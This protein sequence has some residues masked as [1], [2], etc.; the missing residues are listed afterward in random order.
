[1]MEYKVEMMQRRAWQ[2]AKAP[3]GAT[4]NKAVNSMAEADAILRT[5]RESWDK[6]ELSRYNIYKPTKYR[7]VSRM[8][9]E[10]EAGFE[11]EA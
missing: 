3:F 5:V 4:Y 6:E 10:W 11:M 2:P 8:V 1:M 7:I 9:T